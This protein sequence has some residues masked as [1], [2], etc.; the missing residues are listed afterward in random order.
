[1]NPFV[2]YLVAGKDEPL[3]FNNS[4]MYEYVLGSNGLFLHARNKLM[5]VFMPYIIFSGSNKS[6]RGLAEL[7]PYI[8]LPK[9]VPASIL[10]QMVDASYQALPNEI[11]FHLYWGQGEWSLYVP[12][13]EQRHGSVTPLE[14][15]LYAPIEI[16]SHN[17]MPAFFS[18]TD[19]KDETGLRIYGVLGKV[20]RGCTVD[21]KLR[22]S[23]YAHYSVLP[24]QLVFEPHPEVKNV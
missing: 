9:K 11:L 14:D 8:N 13:Q 19:N 5:E 15:N 24:Y 12:K 22:V 21:I 3:S 7:K 10:D 23:I 1:M 20:G 17:S 4:K 18:D 2:D 6:V 16:H